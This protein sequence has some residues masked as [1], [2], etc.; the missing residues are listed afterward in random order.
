[1]KVLI[2]DDDPLV[3]ASLKT[4]IEASGEIDVCGT[5]GG[6]AD[7]VSLYGKCNPDILLMDI[8]MG[9]KTGLD[10]GHEI[11]RR[12]AD[13]RILYLTTFADDEYIIEA[14]RIGAKGYLLKQNFESIVPSLRAVYAGQTVFGEG[15]VAKIPT[16]FGD[17]RP[18]LSNYGLT[19]K[20]GDLLALIAEG[21]SNREI[22]ARLFLSEGTVRNSVSAILEKLNLRGRTQLAVFYYKCRQGG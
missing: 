15:I 8:R 2:V 12:W 19:G 5:G 18:D 10:A 17:V 3:S 6:A 22:A 14:L 20:E 1:M 13:A 21:L 7:A 16:Y 11:L 9:K 4:I